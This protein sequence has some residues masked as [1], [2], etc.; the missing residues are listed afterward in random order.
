MVLIEMGNHAAVLAA[1]KLVQG[2]DRSNPMED[3]IIRPVQRN[4]V[5]AILQQG[6]SYIYL[7]LC[8]LKAI[9]GQIL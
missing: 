7:F 2:V 6:R 4:A 1:F 9:P 5:G 3:R 8:F